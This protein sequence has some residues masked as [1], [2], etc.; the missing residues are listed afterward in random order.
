MKTLTVMVR[1]EYS[2]RPTFFYVADKLSAPSLG[3]ELERQRVSSPQHCDNRGSKHEVDPGIDVELKGRVKYLSTMVN[4]S[5][6]SKGSSCSGL[7][8]DLENKHIPLGKYHVSEQSMENFHNTVKSLSQH[9]VA[10][11]VHC[12]ETSSQDQLSYT[13]DIQGSM[14]FE[15]S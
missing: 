13:C 8:Y 14:R 11:D 6:P 1:E 7:S 15:L 10:V 12:K 9:S 3:N 4:A 5:L 2:Q